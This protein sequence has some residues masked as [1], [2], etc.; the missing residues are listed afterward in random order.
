MGL[1]LNIKRR[2]IPV[3]CYWECPCGVRFAQFSE[4]KGEVDWTVKRIEKHLKDIHGSTIEE[5]AQQFPTKT[6]IK[7]TERYKRVRQ[8]ELESSRT[9]I[10]ENRT[11]KKD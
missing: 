4:P 8:S 10:H 1:I 6:V 7:E 5:L 9:K 3:A 11:P 2:F